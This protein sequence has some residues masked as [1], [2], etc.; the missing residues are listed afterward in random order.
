MS[1]KI[2]HF[3]ALRCAIST[4]SECWFRAM[5]S[6]WFRWETCVSV[7]DLYREWVSISCHD[8]CLILLRDL[9]SGV[10]SLQLV[11]VDFVQW[12]LFDFAEGPA[13]RRAISTESECRFRAM[14]P[15]WFCW[16]TCASV[17]DLYSLWVST[18]CHEICLILAEGPALRCAISTVCE[19]WCRAMK[20]VWFCWGTCPSVCDLYSWWVSILCHK[21]CL[22]LLR[23]LSF[24][25]R[26]LQGVSF[27][28]V[29]WNLFGF[30]EGPAL[31]CAISTVCECRF[32]ATKSVWFC[33]GTCASG[34]DLYSMWVSIS[35]HEICL[36]L[37]R[38]LPFGVRSL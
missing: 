36:V 17:C 24:G 11:S 37:L 21:I 28:F 27:D 16:G 4:E 32:R 6:V 3:P 12:T 35:C 23:N 1:Q 18:S 20:S 25:V 19:C 14:K 2:Y 26:S 10:R 31:R 38:D 13:L 33:W 29:P 15:V 34:C 22:I 8:I 30:A 7:C 9:R 5:K